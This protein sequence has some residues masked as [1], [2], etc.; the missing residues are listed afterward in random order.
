MLS[1]PQIGLEL[2]LLQKSQSH[3]IGS[4]LSWHMQCLECVVSARGIM[5]SSS[6]RLCRQVS[7]P[8]ERRQVA[9]GGAHRGGFSQRVLPLPSS[10]AYKPGPKLASALALPL[11]RKAGVTSAFRIL[12][13]LPDW[14][15]TGAPDDWGRLCTSLRA[16]NER[17]RTLFPAA[18]LGNCTRPSAC[19]ST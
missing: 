19:S 11:Q 1:R 2:R 8:F 18:R 4:S 9:R 15:A 13:K 17:M 6:K 7:M 5:E 12:R 16:R 3:L 10:R 14:C